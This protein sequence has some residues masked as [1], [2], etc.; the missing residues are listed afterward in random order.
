MCCSAASDLNSIGTQH[1]DI[2]VSPDIYKNCMAVG[3]PGFPEK[4]IK[5][6]AAL[7]A[8]GGDYRLKLE[9]LK[10]VT[11]VQAKACTSLLASD[12]VSVSVSDNGKMLYIE[13]SCKGSK[14]NGRCIIQD[15][16]DSIVYREKNGKVL[17]D[18]RRPSD[19]EKMC[20][21]GL[22]DVTIKELVALV[23]TCSSDELELLALGADMNMEAS[24]WG[25]AHR[26]GSAIGAHL[27]DLADGKRWVADDLT[28]ELQIAT[29]AASDVRVSGSPI[30]IMTCAGSGN[31]GI[32][33]MVPIARAA[34]YLHIPR[35]KML[36]ALALSC[37]VT[38]YVKRF[39]GKLSGMCGCGVA[40]GTGVAC[41]L[42]YMLDGS[43]IQM[44][45][46]IKNMAGGITG[47]ICDGAKEG[48]SL[49]L[50]NAVASAVQSAI[51]ALSDVVIPNDNGIVGTTAEQT[52]RNMGTV[53]FPGMSSTDATILEVMQHWK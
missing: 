41:A 6:A 45:N 35:M 30:S 31:H 49:K 37:L 47:M 13:A 21:D 42:T 50:A 44:E 22:T 38:V 29:C 28:T 43:M 9:A 25:L 5:A 16:H 24:K 11:D 19:E 17:L 2:I 10:T 12:G 32:T 46:S 48:C 23:E 40:S 27:K 4:G 18:G 51:L 20:T 36:K 8:I 33:A 53:S 26:P 15:Y 14:G 1:I 52:L 39:S 34:Q 7:G 3:I